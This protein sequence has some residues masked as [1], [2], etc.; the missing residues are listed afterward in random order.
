MMIAHLV[1]LVELGAD[2]AAEEVASAAGAEAP[3]LDVL[4]VAP[5]QVA[6]CT[7]VRHLLLPVD[8][9]DL[10][11]REA[12]AVQRYVGGG[13]E[14]ACSVPQGPPY[15]KKRIDPICCYQL[16]SDNCENR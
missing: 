10:Q 1:G 4:R 8:R 15:S 2:V 12:T 7:I 16:L 5:Q 3:A 14:P 6:H 9:P 13:A 11:A